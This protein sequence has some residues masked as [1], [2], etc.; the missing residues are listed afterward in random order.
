[1]GNVLY[2]REFEV[3]ELDPGIDDATAAIEII[4][5]SRLGYGVIALGAGTDVGAGPFRLV[6]GR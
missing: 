3:A 1:M 2:G 5:Q 6:A 4:A